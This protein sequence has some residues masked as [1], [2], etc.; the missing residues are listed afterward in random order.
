MGGHGDNGIEGRGG[1]ELK[2]AREVKEEVEGKR[3]LGRLSKRKGNDGEDR[4]G[5]WS[6]F[7]FNS[8]SI[9]IN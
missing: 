2:I 9:A 7:S 4:G 5:S 6:K 8:R 3:V 1:V